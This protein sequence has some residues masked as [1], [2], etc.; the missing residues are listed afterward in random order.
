MNLPVVH[1]CRLHSFE[2]VRPWSRIHVVHSIADSLLFCIEFNMM[3]GRN[4]NSNPLTG[5]L[6]FAGRNVLYLAAE[7]GDGL[8]QPF[9]RRL[10]IDLECDVI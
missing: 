8:G 1:T 2:P 3:T 4:L 10:V 6:E 9:Q 5:C 7:V